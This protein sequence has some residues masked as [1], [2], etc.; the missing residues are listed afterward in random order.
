MTVDTNCWS[1]HFWQH[2]RGSSRGQCVVSSVSY[3][4]IGCCSWARSFRG[5]V[6][7]GDLRS[8]SGQKFMD[9]HISNWKIWSAP[10]WSMWRN[11]TWRWRQMF[12]MNHKVWCTMCMLHV[13]LVQPRVHVPR[14]SMNKLCVNHGEFLILSH[15]RDR[16]FWVILGLA[17]GRLKSP[18]RE[19][20]VLPWGQCN[21]VP[22][23]TALLL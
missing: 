1:S 20:T 4:T 11:K 21:L 12:F 8:C 10:H 2:D 13:L 16:A 6:L 17:P 9:R 19:R 23:R 7:S 3:A 22:E 14:T 15:V 5:Q 18:P